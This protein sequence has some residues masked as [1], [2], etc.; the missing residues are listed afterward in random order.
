MSATNLSLHA[1][2]R[3]RACVARG[4]KHTGSCVVMVQTE[5]TCGGG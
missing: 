2:V 4:L 1:C 3:V 5:V